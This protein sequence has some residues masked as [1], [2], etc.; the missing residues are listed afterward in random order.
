MIADLFA[1][2]EQLARA[3][4]TWSYAAAAVLGFLAIWLSPCHLVGLTLASTY[5]HQHAG[6]P[7]QVAL[8]LS[9]FLVA[10][11]A[12]AALVAAATLALGRL[13]GDTGTTGQML[14][15]ALVALAGL[16]LL[17]VVPL[18]AVPGGST[19]S[20]SNGLRSA[21]GLGAAFSVATG[22]CSL[23]FVAP[24]LA[25]PI[26][27]VAS[28]PLGAGAAVVAM[29]VAGHAAGAGLAWAIA[30][31]GANWLGGHASARLRW[32]RTTAGFL[33]VTLAGWMTA[34][35]IMTG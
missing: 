34:N 31:R 4:G 30:Q 19:R 32:A 14:A 17:D 24:L 8:A 7:R 26:A 6:G 27:G 21:F 2:V 3:G 16:M 25:L 1:P 5:L 29:F 33:L 20:G 35:A 13:A 18:P 22:P 12:T 10:M 23:A 11:L 28:T 15:V 9:A